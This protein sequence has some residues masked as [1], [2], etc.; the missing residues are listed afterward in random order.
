[1]SGDYKSIN[2]LKSMSTYCQS[3]DY[4]FINPIIIHKYM[5]LLLEDYKF[6]NPL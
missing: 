5:Y 6:I 2:P 4:K 1:M 3:Q